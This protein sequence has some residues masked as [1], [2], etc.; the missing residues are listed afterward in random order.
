M[1]GWVVEKME[2][3][4]RG[5]CFSG[6]QVGWGWA[7]I[8]VVATERVCVGWL[9]LEIIFGIE[10]SQGRTLLSL[11]QGGNKKYE[12]MGVYAAIDT[13][14]RGVTRIRR[15]GRAVPERKASERTS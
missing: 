15:G 8:P 11:D 2:Y 3:V 4:A 1:R 14:I 6:G 7:Y 10:R 12:S 13:Q 9:F 5:R